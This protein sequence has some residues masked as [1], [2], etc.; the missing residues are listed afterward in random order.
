[1]GPGVAADG[2]AGRDHLME[3]FRVIGRVL[4]DREEGR[5]QAL[6]GER[7]EHRLG[8]VEPGSVVEGEHDLAGAKRKRGGK[9]LAADPG[10]SRRVD[11]KNAARS[12]RIRPA[13]GTRL[14]ARHQDQP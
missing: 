14:R 1:M 9:L 13:F 11:G 7:F 3:D 12:Q 10:R 2:V 5:P 8:V 6:I 4:A